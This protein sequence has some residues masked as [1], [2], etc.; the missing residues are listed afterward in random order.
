MTL[1]SVHGFRNW[2][3]ARM[4]ASSLHPYLILRLPLLQ[5]VDGYK[6]ALYI[7]DVEVQAWAQV[8]DLHYAVN[9][10][11]SRRIRAQVLHSD[12]GWRFRTQRS[13]RRKSLQ[14]VR[15]VLADE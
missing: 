14:R 11:I 6:W 13:T 9:N 12:Q 10:S 7:G 2:L 8:F 3:I 5:E 4:N 15:D 1:H